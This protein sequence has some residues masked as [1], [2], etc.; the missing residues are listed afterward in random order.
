MN[1][2]HIISAI[3]CLSG[4]SSLLAQT[5]VNRAALGMFQPILEAADNPENP[6]TEPKIDLGRML[7]Y[8]TRLSKNRS[9]SCNTCH[10]LASYGD[11]GRNTSKGIHD[12]LG[13]RSAPTVYNAAIHIAQF[14]DGRAKDVEA[15]AVGPVTNPVEMGMP[16]A[17]YVLKVLRSI[18]GY[19]KAFAVAFP[20]DKEPLTYENMGKAIGA[21]ERKLMTPAPFDDF[22][23]GDETALTEEQKVGLNT[24]MSTGC[25]VCHNGMGVGG[26]LYQ[27]LG[28]VKEWVT[29]D[30]GR[31]EETKVET[32]KFFFKVPSLRNITETGP[33][34]HD[35]SIESLEE[36]VSKMAEYQLGRQLPKDDVSSIIS[37]LGS[38]KGRVDPDYIK[39]PELPEDGPDTPKG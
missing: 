35:G 31:F 24:F 7:Y 26:H 39:I 19:V 10:D 36:I 21:F 33:Y 20:E 29:K 12:Q 30:L 34:L 15:Q 2:Y 9:V 1:R 37:F 16:D 4:T 38:L 25:T 8:D 3:L 18:P 17:D 5:V 28:L 32:D 11:D 22:L 13:G 6:L 27:K 23:K 14:W